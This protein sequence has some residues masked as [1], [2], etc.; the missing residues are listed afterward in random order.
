MLVDSLIIGAAC[1]SG[2]DLFAVA[3]D[4]LRRRRPKKNAKAVSPAIPTIPPTTPP[5]IAPACEVPLEEDDVSLGEE[6]A[7][8]EEWVECATEAVTDL[9]TEVLVELVELGVFVMADD[10]GE[11]SANAV[12]TVKVLF[13]V[14]SSN[15]HPG[16]TVSAGIPGGNLKE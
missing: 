1:Q 8:D 13:F 14:T 16:T 9:V 4:V 6:E 15:A 11:V 2:I 3:A 5:A 10:S 12:E 7:D